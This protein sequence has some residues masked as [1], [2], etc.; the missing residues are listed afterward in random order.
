MI[1]YIFKTLTTYAASTSRD[2]RSWPHLRGLE[3]ADP[4]PSSK[5]PINVLIGADLY[6]QLLV[7]PL[8]EGPFGSPTAQ[9]T[10]LGW[11]ISGPI[12]NTRNPQ[13]A[14]ASTMH[15]AIAPNTDAILS[16]F[17]E[18]EEIP[19]HH[20]T[21]E[22]ESCEITSLAST[23]SRDSTGRYIVCLP[24]RHGSPPDIGD[25]HNIALARYTQHE[26]RLRKKPELARAYFDFLHE[27]E[28][29]GHMERVSGLDVIKIPLYIPHH[30]VIRESSATTRVRVVF[31]A[32]SVTSNGTSLRPEFIVVSQILDLVSN[33]KFYLSGFESST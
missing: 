5:E 31:N 33:L 1:A 27:Y 23:H 15:C 28:S 13:A 14:H 26:Y 21:P 19:S 22:E 10:T 3:L 29:M 9:L 32:S 4:D 20:L 6:G 2:I 17:W 24:F 7:G 8:K 30:P 25:S 11:I 18:T 12:A 16:Q